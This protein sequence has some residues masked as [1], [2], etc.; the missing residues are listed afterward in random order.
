VILGGGLALTVVGMLVRRWHC[1]ARWWPQ[2]ASTRWCW[3]LAAAPSLRRVLEVY[4]RPRPRSAARA[5]DGVWPL[6]GGDGVLVQPPLR[7]LLPVGLLL[8]VA[9]A[10]CSGRC[11]S[12]AP[13]DGRRASS[14]ARLDSR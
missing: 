1:S 6:H 9:A 5:P 13:P 14:T 2:A 12:T 4:R 10:A 7:E 8:D 3:W 11:C